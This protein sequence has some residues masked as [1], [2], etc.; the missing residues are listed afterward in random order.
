[1]SDK[2]APTPN[3]ATGMLVG[4]AVVGFPLIKGT[5]D[6]MDG[7]AEIITRSA[8]KNGAENE[9]RKVA[10]FAQL[11]RDKGDAARTRFEREESTETLAAGIEQLEER[12]SWL[13]ATNIRQVLDD[14]AQVSVYEIRLEVAKWIVE[15][16]RNA[17]DTV[18]GSDRSKT[19][20]ASIREIRTEI[21]KQSVMLL[22]VDLSSHM[23]EPSYALQSLGNAIGKGVYRVLRIIFLLAL[24]LCAMWGA[25]LLYLAITR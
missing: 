7:I 24:T 12:A 8:M 13:T 16:L 3:L 19:V 11:I 21:A 9:S 6:A 20:W 17:M 4:T 23:G 10:R 25:G 2:N 15:P 5:F 1:M 22:S 18:S 14:N